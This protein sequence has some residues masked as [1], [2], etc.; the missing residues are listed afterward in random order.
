MVFPLRKMLLGPVMDHI[1]QDLT[2][3]PKEMSRDRPRIP[4]LNQRPGRFSTAPLVKSTSL[5][6]ASSEPTNLSTIHG[7]HAL[8]H[9]RLQM[10]IGWGIAKQ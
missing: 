6:H 3:T 5:V 9:P 8:T 10:D 7:H 4:D 1:G 2:E